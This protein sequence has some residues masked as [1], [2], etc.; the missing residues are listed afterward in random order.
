MLHKKLLSHQGSFHSQTYVRWF[1]TNPLLHL[2]QCSLQRLA[3]PNAENDLVLG[4]FQRVFPVGVVVETVVVSQPPSL[5]LVPQVV[6][7]TQIVDRYM[8]LVDQ[9]LPVSPEQFKALHAP[10][11]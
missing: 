8:H 11:Y 3:E 2:G 5:H 1:V 4:R 6:Q 7:P 9:S 10:A